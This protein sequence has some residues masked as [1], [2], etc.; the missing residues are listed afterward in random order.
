[1]PPKVS[2]K[3]EESAEEVRQYPCLFDKSHPDYKL[4]AVKS[5]SWLEI[6]TKLGYDS[7]KTAETTW[8]NLKKLLSKRRARVRDVNRSGY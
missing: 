7:E 1:M 4:E 6:A 5:R 8:D 3:Y 2:P